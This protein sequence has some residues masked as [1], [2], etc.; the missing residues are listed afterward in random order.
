MRV[1]LCYPSIVPGQKAKY[2]LQPLG[3]LYIAALLR[4][5][6]FPAAVIDADIE[7]LTLQETAARILATRPDL[8]GLSLMTPQLQS[9]LACATLLKRSRPDLPVVLGGAHIDSTRDDVFAMSDAFDFAVQ[10]EGEL[11]LLEACQR[12]AQRPPAART[13]DLADCLAPIPNAIY[14]DATGRVVVNPERPFLRDLDELASVDYDMVDVS[15][16]SIPTMAGK[17]VISMMLS[18]GCPYSCTF[19]DAPITM[20]KKL[21]FWSTPRLVADI[22]RYRDRY[23]VRDFVFKDSTFTANRR[24]A[25]EF[26]QALIDADLGIRFRCNTRAN[27]V[28]P[29]LLERMRRAGCYIINF[30]VES[31]DADILKR[32]RKEVDFAEVEDA[33]ARCRQLGIRTYATFLIGNPGETELTARR[34]IELARRIRPSLAVFNVATAYPGTPLY[35]DAV[36]DGTIEPRWWAAQRWD[37][38]ENSAFQVRWGWTDA[39]ALRF[40][41]FD[42]ELWQRRATRAFYLRPRFLW[43]T[44]VFTLSNP[45]FLRHVA[46]LG[47][48]LLP[49]YRLRAL[50]GRVPEDE[51]HAILGKCPSLPNPGYTPK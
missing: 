28:P 46:S 32:I 11:T 6:G 31:G 45:G 40:D 36:R 50:F 22:R 9:A 7:G 16:Y 23:G 38:S 25:T 8:V 42:P 3:V 48:E 30:G 24:W 2:G 26:C 19:C 37:A 44:A 17:H 47:V 21:R 35:D 51:R 49:F 27:L 43:D 18:R 20:G 33:F 41:D 10:G 1:T 4:R 29:A 12:L 15:R 14:R 13:R 34:T 5:H 39:G